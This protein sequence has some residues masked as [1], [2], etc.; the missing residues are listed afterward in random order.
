MVRDVEGD[1]EDM[2]H[3]AQADGECAAAAKGCKGKDFEGTVVRA[4]GCEGAGGAQLST[5]DV[6]RVQGSEGT[7]VRVQVYK[8][9]AGDATRLLRTTQGAA[10]EVCVMQR[11]TIAS[12]CATD[13]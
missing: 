13:E 9:A 2:L 3:E 4:Q 10:G 1:E 12:E 11:N 8:G 6:G 7:I 5:V